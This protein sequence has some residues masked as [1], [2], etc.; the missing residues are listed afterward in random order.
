ML[1]RA[2]PLVT[3]LS[4]AL[5][6]PGA[7]G[8]TALAARSRSST[9]AH[10]DATR[11]DCSAAYFQGDH[12]LGPA[13]LAN[14]GASGRELNG[15]RRTGGLTPAKFLET[16]WN[17]RASSGNGGW[18]YPPDNGYAIGADGKPVEF[19]LTLRTGSDVDRYGSEY[20]RFLSPAGLPYAMRSI[21]PQNLVSTPPESCNYHDYEVLRSFTVEAGPIAPWFAQPGYGLQY[22]L[23]ATLLPGH[24]PAINVKWLLTNGYLQLIRQPQ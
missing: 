22:Q 1:R 16:Y 12:R 19:R 5:I 15:Y 20:G 3:V 10:A 7:T 6:V 13:D 11:R 8:A 24:P 9:S 21:P 18:S 4:I 17:P 2:L 14:A 23:E